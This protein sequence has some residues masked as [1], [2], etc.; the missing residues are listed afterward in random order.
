MALV[1]IVFFVLFALG[2]RWAQLHPERIVSKGL[3]TGRDTFGARLF[4]A[5]IAV[6]GTFAVFFGT[7]SVIFTALSS[8]VHSVALIWIAHLIAITTGIIAA[9]HVRREVQGQ[10]KYVSDTPNGWWP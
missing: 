5:Q 9:V 10:P 8:V 6:I 7:Q 4:R 1:A 3:F 2:G